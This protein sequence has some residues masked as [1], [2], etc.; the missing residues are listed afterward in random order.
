MSNDNNQN[1]KDGS[2]KIGRRM[3]ES[4]I[5]LPSLKKENT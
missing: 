2:L 5:E 3:S 4:R 1:N